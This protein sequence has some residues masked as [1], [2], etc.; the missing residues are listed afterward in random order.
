MS[1]HVT[2]VRLTS[3]ALSQ[4]S[5]K[6][7]SAPPP[8]TRQRDVLDLK[9][10]LTGSRARTPSLRARSVEIS[11]TVVKKP[12]P[13][14]AA[15]ALDDIP[16]VPEDSVAL[17]PSSK[18]T[19]VD[20]DDDYEHLSESGSDNDKCNTISLD[21]PSSEVVDLEPI[22]PKKSKKVAPQSKGKGKVSVVFTCE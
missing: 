20:K 6:K 18:R 7:K 19:R 9:N 14:T 8:T 10:I 16:E 17:A 12:K 11:D 3:R 2:I 5:G 21:S 1:H 13:Q 15:M 4:I 22:P